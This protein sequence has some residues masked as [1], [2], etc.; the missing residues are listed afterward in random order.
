MHKAEKLVPVSYPA[1]YCSLLAPASLL[2]V[3]STRLWLW[4]R[5]CC[6]GFQFLLL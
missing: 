3:S 6:K 2:E 1:L 4:Q 5:L